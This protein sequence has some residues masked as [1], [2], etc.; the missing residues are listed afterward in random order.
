LNIYQFL[1][2]LKKLKVENIIMKK[3]NILLCIPAVLLAF[4]VIISCSEYPKKITPVLIEEGMHFAGNKGNLVIKTQTEWDNLICSRFFA[5][6]TCSQNFAE[7]NFNFDMYQIIAVIDEARPDCC[8]WS[9]NIVSI[10]EYSDEI[11]VSI[12][13]VNKGGVLS[14]LT[15]PYQIV[16]IPVT[17]KD[18]A[19]KHTNICNVPYY[20]PYW[21]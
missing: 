6:A 13:T 19:F 7:K 21:R 17:T 1:S 14:E 16:K 2:Y 4:T 15:Q 18:I 20:S 10:R 8:G 5:A 12:C 9:I 11:V 3:R